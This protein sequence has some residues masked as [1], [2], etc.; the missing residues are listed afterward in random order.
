MSH[1]FHVSENRV[2]LIFTNFS[3]LNIFDDFEYL[4][5]AGFVHL[6]FDD[7]SDRFDI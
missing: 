4:K 7:R 5:L 2:G 6:K 3:R 1:P